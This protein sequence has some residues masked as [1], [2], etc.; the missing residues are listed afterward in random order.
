[1]AEK[2]TQYTIRSVPARVDRALRKKAQARGV[3]LNRL[4]LEALEAEAG[5]GATVPEKSDLDRF[6]GTWV[7]DARVDRALAAQRRVDPRDWK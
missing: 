4:A 3:S 7:Q 1:M 2:A 5:V 6:R